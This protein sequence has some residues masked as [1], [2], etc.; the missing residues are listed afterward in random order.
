LHLDRHAGC[1]VSPQLF[2]L[3]ERL[4]GHTAVLGLAVL[5]HPVI[6]LARGRVLGK[7]GRW[8]A[9]LAAALIAL[10]SVAG[11]LLYPHYRGQ[12][13]PTLIAENVTV[14]LAFESK[15]HLA[16]ACLCLSLSGVAVALAAP[17]H[18]RRVAL[19]LLAG[20]WVCGLVTGGLGIFVASLS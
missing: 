16:F 20:G 18:A 2:A 13:K 15:E 7:G 19:P 3:L 8:S 11:W 10:P 6:T 1:A 9:G 14:A 12:I 5:L 4:H 17:Q